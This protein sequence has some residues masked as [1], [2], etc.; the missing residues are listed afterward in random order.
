MSLNFQE[1][2]R[3]NETYRQIAHLEEKLADLLKENKQLQEIVDELHHEYDYSEL[4]HQ[5]IQKVDDYNKLLCTEMN[6]SGL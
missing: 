5:T 4:K 2:L 1:S 6:S 3:S